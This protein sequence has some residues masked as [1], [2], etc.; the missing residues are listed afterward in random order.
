MIRKMKKEA[1]YK[2]FILGV[3]LALSAMSYA[4][5][6]PYASGK[7]GGF[8]KH[9]DLGIT[10]GSTGIGVDVSS[11]INDVLRLRTGFS[12]MPSWSQ[13]MTFGIQ[14]GDDPSTSDSK[15]EKLRGFLEN[16]T[17]RSVDNKID[18]IGRPMYYNFKLLLDVYPL[19]NKH[20]RVTAGFFLGN[21]RI[22]R[23]Y[24]TTEDMSSLLAVCM[25]N[26]MYEKL[27]SGEP[28]LLYDNTYLDPEVQDALWQ[29][30]EAYGR[31]G[32]P[33]G[34]REDGTTYYME[35]D[36]DSM[37]KANMYANAF[38]PYVG[39]G[40][41]GP[42]SKKN[43]KYTIGVD[44][45]VMFWGGVPSVKT[46]DGT[47]LV[48]DVKDVPGKVGRYVDIVNGF[49]VFPVVELKIARKLF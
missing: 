1:M 42:L 30:F 32:V 6:N 16:F 20:W 49:K 47:D 29:K 19:R 37:A 26:N 22:A 35:P 17:G 15:F 10:L 41:E 4:Q 34:V 25:Y 24:N 18:M 27:E 2:I 31:M 48:Y 38:K 13:E 8:L 33:M 9:M 39:L 23:A 28:F 7:T 5:G 21:E 3:A 36:D 43:D 46:H 14:V 45:G 44:C 11:P 12:F 40:Y